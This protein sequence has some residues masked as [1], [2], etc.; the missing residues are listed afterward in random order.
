M[1]ILHFKTTA[2]Q[3]PSRARCL[4]GRHERCDIRVD[5]PRVSGE[6]ALVRWRGDYWELQDLGSRNGTFVGERRLAA[7]EHVRLDPGATFSLSR[8]AA[9][10]ELADA[11]PPGAVAHHKRTGHWLA[12]GRGILALP[13][14]QKP[15]VTLFA[16][17]DGRWQI[18]ID[19]HVR[20]AVDRE[21][22]TVDGEVYTL[23]IPY[24]EMETIQTSAAGP[25]LE[26]IRLR[27][28]VTPDEE[29]VEATVLFGDRPKQLPARR[30][31]YLLLTLA[32]MWLA[33]EGVPLSLRGWI[34]RDELCDKLDMDVNKLNVEI[35]RVR[36]QLAAF[37]V[38]GAAG[39]IER[40]HGTHEIRIGVHDIEVVKL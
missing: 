4:L 24:P 1:G 18:E 39:V 12:S 27:L 17:G 19:D 16:A 33:D 23:E 34:G 5:N 40:R 31:H 37:G 36:K 38:Q 26:T 9:V 6:H 10:F 22:I 21:E 7:G 35:H 30:Y 28:G 8:A 14:E 11:S 2:Q 20:S 32:R 3:V 15:I 25:L 13:S 29:Q